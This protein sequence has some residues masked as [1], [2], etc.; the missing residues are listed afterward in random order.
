MKIPA[1]AAATLWIMSGLIVWASCFVALYVGVSL[2]C[3]YAWSQPAI[4]GLL[5]GLWGLHL[6]A[7]AWMSWRA[8]AVCRRLRPEDGNLAFAWR[9][10]V[11]V[12]V[13]SLAG[14]LWTGLPILAVTPCA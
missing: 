14:T 9:A 13:F 8:L 1:G 12:H 4:T 10:I 7:L 5:L 11:A 6:A 3:I 2:G